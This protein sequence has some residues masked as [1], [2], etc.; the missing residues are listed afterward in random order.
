[1][2]SVSPRIL[3]WPALVICSSWLIV[4]LLLWHFDLVPSDTDGRRGH[5]L[6]AY[7][8]C[9]VFLCTVFL[10]WDSCIERKRGKQKAHVWAY[11]VK[12]SGRPKK[13]TLTFVMSWSRFILVIVFARPFFH[14]T[15]L[16][17]QT[18][19]GQP[20]AKFS[21]AKPP[22]QHDQRCRPNINQTAAPRSGLL[23]AAPRKATRP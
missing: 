11:I 10:C 20:F 4:T 2:I 16:A 19:H 3:A 18:T 23:R 1:M 13:N 8:A 22:I 15:I 21:T 6:R 14:R 9:L 17:N 12:S 5:I 7:E